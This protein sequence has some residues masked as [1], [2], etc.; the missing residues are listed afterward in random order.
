MFEFIE[1]VLFA[2][3]WIVC[4]AFP[5]ILAGALLYWLVNTPLRRQ[6][7]ARF[8]L[9]LLALGLRNKLGP[10]RTLTNLST[11]GDRDLNGRFHLIASFL[12]TGATLMEAIERAPR[13]LPPRIMALLKIGS[14]LGDLS[15]V[16]EPAR[17]MLHDASPA[18]RKAKDYFIVLAFVVSPAIILGVVSTQIFVI[19]KYEAILANMLNGADYE[20]I[21]FQLTHLNWCW[22]GAQIGMLAAIWTSVIVYFVNPIATSWEGTRIARFCSSMQFAVP[23]KRKRM[24]RDFAAALGMLLDAGIPEDRALLMA[25]DCAENLKFIGLARQCAKDLQV[26]KSLS[27]AMAPLDPSQQFDWR[28]Q[29]A[30]RSDKAA[31]RALEAWRDALDAKAFQQEQ[32]FSQVFAS[33][34]VIWNG[35]V[36]GIFALA[37]FSSLVR[38]IVVASPW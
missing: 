19:P 35:A 11:T 9:D 3:A 8:F 32:A 27:D 13:I 38:M 28:L 23:W 18:G 25:A 31:G 24:Q 26:G 17:A 20:P 1:I 2:L 34:M 4:F 16:M 15:K 12:E 6:E 22:A 36:V 10:E 30:R 29:N 7:N 37:V 33:G 5:L 21:W 14:E